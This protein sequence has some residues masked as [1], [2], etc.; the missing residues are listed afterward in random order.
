LQNS[1]KLRLS[2]IIP[3]IVFS[4]LIALI[5]VVLFSS[6]IF[7][8]NLTLNLHLRNVIATMNYVG[9]TEMVGGQSADHLGNI[10]KTLSPELPE[11]VISII[12][13]PNSTWSLTVNPKTKMVY[14][15]NS[16]SDTMSVINGKNNSVIGNIDLYNGLAY[17]DVNPET[18]DVYVAYESRD[19][20]HSGLSVIDTKFNPPIEEDIILD[21]HFQVTDVA[22]NPSTN[23]TYI[24]HGP[25]QK[26]SVVDGKNNNSVSTIGILNSSWSLAIDPITN[27][28][29]ST[30]AFNDTVS[31]ID[32]HKDQVVKNITVALPSASAIA[33]NPTTHKVYVANEPAN[34]I[35]IIDG[36]SNTVVNT[37]IHN[38]TDRYTKDIAIDSK[39]NTVFIC[40]ERGLYIIDGDTD[41]IVT[42]FALG[43]GLV[44]IDVDP[45]TGLVYTADLSAD[46][47]YVLD[48]KKALKEPMTPSEASRMNINAPGIRI[49]GSV[50]GLSVNTATNAIYVLDNELN[51]LNIIDGYADKI[52]KVLNVNGSP[53]K[54]GINENTNMIYLPSHNSTQVISATTNSSVGMVLFNHTKAYFP[55]DIVVS[56]SAN[57]I[58]VAYIVDQFS[59]DI[60]YEDLE[61]LKDIL[62]EID[63]KTNTI[64]SK[65]ELETIGDL[66][67]DEKSN[68]IYNSNYLSNE[69]N[70]IAPSNSL[71]D[72]EMHIDRNITLAD[73][74][75]IA[76]NPVNDL[77]Y[78]INLL[79]DE[80]VVL[81]TF[82]DRILHREKTTGTPSDVVVNPITNK[83]YVMNRYTDSVSVLN[84]TGIKQRD[85]PVGSYFSQLDINPVTNKVYVTEP[86]SGAVSVINGYSD[87]LTAVLTFNV[88]P[89]NLGEIRCN[90]QKIS[91]KQPARYDVDTELVCEALPKNDNIVFNSWAG[92][93]LSSNDNPTNKFEPLK[94]GNITA[95]FIQSPPPVQISPEALAGLYTIVLTAI[96]GWFVPGIARWIT[97]KRQGKFV[98]MYMTEIFEAYD[99]LSNSKDK[100]FQRL[101]AIRRQVAE[102]FAKGKLSESQ[103]GILNDKIDEY[104]K[105]DINPK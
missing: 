69:I 14:V 104:Y 54:M 81:D 29:Y 90:G 33:V 10:V 89:P 72:T 8:E 105:M 7:L 66:A 27:T 70:V 3:A 6:Y 73:P 99:K 94:Y 50:N 68:L 32:G 52:I 20:Q 53:T 41:K 35:S 95:N 28:V 18:D 71:A 60:P 16:D 58:Y 21:A 61:N 56:T 15:P 19:H 2:Q 34:R 24:A 30:D 64:V 5:I 17:V 102:R 39:T 86:D 38:S 57:R 97:A 87:K 74:S 91:D 82:T 48:G 9:Q 79:K 98:N 25:G 51:H 78:V 96:I 11:A 46:K 47:I 26:I 36:K 23:K 100:Y 1:L 31:V 67:F 4:T 63:G 93:Y 80:L 85:V 49:A 45:D 12:D 59:I 83:V 65:L 44:S 75:A 88:N 103:Y 76:V 77:L 92:D 37:I 42:E 43:K 13:I 22:V 101:E 55:S 40:N 84:S 62:Y